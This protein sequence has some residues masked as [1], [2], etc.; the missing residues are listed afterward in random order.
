MCLSGDFLQGRIDA[1]KELITA[2][3]DAI[4]AIATGGVETYTLDTGQ[5]RQTVT[6][7]NLKDMNESLDGLYNRLSTLCAR[8]NGSGSTHIRPAW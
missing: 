5:T 1:T 2:Y 7:Q 6:K 3:E 8:Q 4:A